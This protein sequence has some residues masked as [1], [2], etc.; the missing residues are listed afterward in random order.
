M[1]STAS[2]NEKPKVSARRH[3]RPE[4]AVKLI[5]AADKRGR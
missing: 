4:E 3:L 2:D 5:A 1:S